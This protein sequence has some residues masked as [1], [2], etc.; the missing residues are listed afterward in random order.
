MQALLL[1]IGIVNLLVSD[2][3]HKWAVLKGGQGGGRD[4]NP[5]IVKLHDY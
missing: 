2:V 1:E 3:V 4:S 5:L